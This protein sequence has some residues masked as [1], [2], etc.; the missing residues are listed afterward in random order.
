MEENRQQVLSQK[1]RQLEK[2]LAE[3]ETRLVEENG[4][5]FREIKDIREFV[6]EYILR[7]GRKIYLLGEGRL[8]NLAAEKEIWA[9]ALAY[10]A[11]DCI[12]CGLCDF[13]CP[14][15][16][17]LTQSIKRAKMEAGK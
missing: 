12:E 4:R 2:E 7:D 17:R 16:R 6:D 11:M 9:Q 13:V 15:H 10:N 8:I 3:I 14:A 1:Y 5:K